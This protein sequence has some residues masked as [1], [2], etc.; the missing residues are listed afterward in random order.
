VPSITGLILY[1]RLLWIVNRAGVAGLAYAIFKFEVKGVKKAG[2]AKRLSFRRRVQSADAI[3]GVVSREPEPTGVDETAMGP[4]VRR[5]D[6]RGDD[7]MPP[8]KP[9]ADAERQR[10]RRAGRNCWH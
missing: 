3:E 6:K 8:L 9:P 1:N 7:V 5:D 10:R 4:G 2:K